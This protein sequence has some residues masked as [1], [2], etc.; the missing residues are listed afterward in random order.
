MANEE[1]EIQISKDGKVT[2]RTIGIKGAR[3]LDAAEM[4]ALIVGKEEQRE[5]TS[6]Y[7]EQDQS[8]S[9]HLG[10]HQKYQ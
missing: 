1:L 2:I 9:Q 5:L 6:E 7:Y 4:L 8:Q 10:I 3:C